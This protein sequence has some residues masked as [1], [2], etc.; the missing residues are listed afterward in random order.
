MTHPAI[1][2]ANG[3]LMLMITRG[4]KNTIP[5]VTRAEQDLA[6]TYIYIGQYDLCSTPIL[7]LTLGHHLLLV[8]RYYLNDPAKY[9]CTIFI[10]AIVIVFC[11]NNNIRIAEPTEQ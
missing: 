11:D 10:L 9:R 4:T 1:F 5:K 2:Y 7:I 8:L 3:M 6:V